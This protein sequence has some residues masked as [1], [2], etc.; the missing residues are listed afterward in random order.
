MLQAPHNDKPLRLSSK[1]RAPGTRADCTTIPVGQLVGVNS[2]ELKAMLS[3]AAHAVLDSRPST[4]QVCCLS[5]TFLGMLPE[6]Q[7]RL[8]CIAVSS[9][10][11][12][13][14]ACCTLRS[15]LEFAVMH[16]QCT[17]LPWTTR[18]VVSRCAE[19]SSQHMTGSPVGSSPAQRTPPVSS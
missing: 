9:H 2:T 5:L 10:G 12:S 11:V 1:L 16:V 6:I 8:C 18:P 17:K 14:V 13:H 4:Q 15:A 3:E 7:P 19:S